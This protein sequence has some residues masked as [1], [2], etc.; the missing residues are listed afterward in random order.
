MEPN[1]NFLS[2]YQAKRYNVQ[3]II[4]MPDSEQKYMFEFVILIL[5]GAEQNSLKNIAEY[6]LYHRL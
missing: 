5:G 4:A 3:G 2:L 6:I 1:T